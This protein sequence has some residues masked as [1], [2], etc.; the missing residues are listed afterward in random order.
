MTLESMGEDAL[1]ARLTRRLRRS[2]EVLTG[3][4]DDC[5]V[6]RQAN[7]SLLLLKTDAVVEGVHFLPTTPPAQ[8][9]WKALCR[10]ISDIAAMGGTPRWA[11]ITLAAPG[12][13]R[14]TRLESI[15]R[16]LQKAA[17]AYGVTVV[18]GE[19]TSTNGPLLLS[20]ALTGEIRRGR[21]ILRSGARAGDA[22]LVTG[23]LGATQARHHLTFRPRVEQGLWLAANHP[24]RA[25]MDLSDGL[26]RDLPRMCRASGLGV[27]MDWEAIPRRRGADLRAALTD[28]EDYELLFTK[29]WGRVAR[30]K[31]DWEKAF[32]SVPLS[33][34][35][36]M[37][38]DGHLPPELK[39]G[40]EHFSG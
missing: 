4:G 30:L 24:P 22:V 26:A 20:V 13:C 36:R 19:T 2:K 28:G 27:A 32:P 9:G 18:G 8:I 15:Y 39:G 40:F 29:P 21:A 10:G 31:Q 16:G 7:G 6:V 11:L 37:T 35:G 17:D 1:V 5:A 34:I 3:V 14:V 38:A 12:K 33:L 25:M 23:Q